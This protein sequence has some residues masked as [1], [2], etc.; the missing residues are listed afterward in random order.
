MRKRNLKTENKGDQNESYEKRARAK[1]NQIF[2][3]SLPIAIALT[4]ILV[5]YLYTTLGNTFQL[6]KSGLPNAS[7]PNAYDPVSDSINLSI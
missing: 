7:L 5:T 2:T 3:Y 1:E 6:E 4:A